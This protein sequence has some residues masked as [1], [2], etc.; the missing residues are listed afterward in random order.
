MRPIFI[1][2]PENVEVQG[3]VMLVLRQL[4]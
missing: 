1:E 3:K 2:K 4:E